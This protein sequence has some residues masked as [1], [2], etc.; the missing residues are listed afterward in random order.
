[1]WIFIVCGGGV[2]FVAFV[3][4]GGRRFYG[5]ESEFGECGGKV[6]RFVQLSRVPMI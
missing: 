3:A 5:R 1:M 2:E 4:L 6:V